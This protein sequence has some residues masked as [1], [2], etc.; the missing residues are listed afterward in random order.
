MRKI[1]RIDEYRRKL[2]NK[3]NHTREVVYFCSTCDARFV[4]IWPNNTR[5][6]KIQWRGCEHCGTRSVFTQYCSGPVLGVFI[7]P[8]L[9][10]AVLI[11]LRYLFHHT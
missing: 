8:V 1:N 10:V 9:T 6:P 11:V 5:P 2:A 7:W 4:D 3:M